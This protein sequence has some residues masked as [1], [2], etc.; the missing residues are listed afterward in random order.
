MEQ[1]GEGGWAGNEEWVFGKRQCRGM[2]RAKA[3]AKAESEVIAWELEE[4]RASSR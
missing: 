3:W 4:Q 1:V 2:K